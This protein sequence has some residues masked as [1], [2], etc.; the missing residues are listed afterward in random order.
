MSTVIKPVANQ[1]SLTSANTIYNSPIVYISA[2]SSAVI[3]VANSTVTIGTFTLP[4]NQYI[5]VSK[6][7]TDTIAANIAVLAT[8]ASYR[9]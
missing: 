5:F 9:G 1:I 4:A 8:A 6:N 3:T 2:T 7:P